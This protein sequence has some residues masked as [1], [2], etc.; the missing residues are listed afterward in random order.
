MY[1]SVANTGSIISIWE[2]TVGSGT[3]RITSRGFQSGGNGAS[4]G[5]AEAMYTPTSTTLTLN[6]GL[7]AAAAGTASFEAGSTTPMYLKVELV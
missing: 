3:Q 7:H 1:H 2:G 6:G 4:V 5:F